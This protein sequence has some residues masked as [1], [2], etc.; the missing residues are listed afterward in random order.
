MEARRQGGECSLGVV[1]GVKRD[2]VDEIERNAVRKDSSG[3][4][5]L[6]GFGECEYVMVERER[7]DLSIDVNLQQKET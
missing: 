3:P 2:T 7:D 1:R 4:Q 5:L 6:S